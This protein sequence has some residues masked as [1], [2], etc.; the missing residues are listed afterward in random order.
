MIL[1][2]EDFS[3]GDSLYVVTSKW[4]YRFFWPAFEVPQHFLFS[5]FFSYYCLHHYL[6][7]LN[8]FVVFINF[9]F[10]PGHITILP[11]DIIDYPIPGQPVTLETL[12]NAPRMFHIKNFATEQE[13]KKIF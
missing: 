9:Y 13:V 7:I 2:W 12:H 4:G 3:D 5:N 11:E 10:Q 8:A 6:L 1:R